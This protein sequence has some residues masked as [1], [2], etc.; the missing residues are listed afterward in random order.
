MS[1]PDP[2]TYSEE[3]TAAR[4]GGTLRRMLVSSTKPHHPKGERKVR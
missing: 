1:K 2:N 3:E 4:R